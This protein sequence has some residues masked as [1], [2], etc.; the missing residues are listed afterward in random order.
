MVDVVAVA[1]ATLNQITNGTT[2]VQDPD[3][4]T[5]G[6]AVWMLRG[7]AEGYI[8]EDKAHRWL[9]YAQALVVIEGDVPLDVL[10]ELNRGEPL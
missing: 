6:H 4:A 7:I 8:T 10:M 1:K 2:P 3:G 9:G 5:L